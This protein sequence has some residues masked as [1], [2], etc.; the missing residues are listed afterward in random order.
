[1]S[2]PLPSAAAAPQRSTTWTTANSTASS[3]TSTHS[4]AFGRGD[5]AECD[6]LPGTSSRRETL[7]PP[8]N[9]AAVTKPLRSAAVLL[10]EGGL[11]YSLV[12]GAALS[13]VESE[14]LSIM[15]R[16][17]ELD[18]YVLTCNLATD[19]AEEGRPIDGYTCLLRGLRHVD[20]ALGDDE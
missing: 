18:N 1:A 5:R 8:G 13:R 10:K 7:R 9:Q 2:S 15:I 20:E 11:P 6:F 12:A 3:P 19:L 16:Q 17:Q 4:S 14:R